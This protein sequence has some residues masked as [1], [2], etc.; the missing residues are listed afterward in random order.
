MPPYKIIFRLTG[1]R[2]DAHEVVGTSYLRGHICV[3]Y[4]V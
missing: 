3:N 4:N 2:D 1:Q